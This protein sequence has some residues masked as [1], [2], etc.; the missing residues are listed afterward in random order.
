MLEGVRSNASPDGKIYSIRNA[1]FTLK[2]IMP[3]AAT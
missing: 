3:F 1:G 2:R